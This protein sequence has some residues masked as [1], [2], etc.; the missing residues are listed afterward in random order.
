MHTP[1]LVIGIDT[2]GTYTDAVL[3]NLKT[4]DVLAWA[5]EP[6]ST[7]NPALAIKKTLAAIL[8]KSHINP[9]SIDLVIVSTTLATNALVENQGAEVG[10]LVIGHDQRLDVPVADFRYIPGGH[11]ARGIEAEPLGMDYLVQAIR[12]MQDHVDTYAICAMLAFDDPSHELVAAKAIE[13]LDP[14]PVFSSHQASTRPG[15]RE[16]ATT[17]VLNARLLPVMQ[18]FLTSISQTMME[19]GLSCPVGIARGDCRVMSL[20]Q[21]VRNSSSTVASGPAATAVFGA[22]IAQGQTA[23]VV[24]VGGTTSDITLICDGQPV[25]R[26][27]GMVV[28]SWSTHVRAVEMRTV[29]LGGDSLISVEHGNLSIGPARVLPMSQVH[30]QV[31]KNDD[32]QTLANPVLWLGP[33]LDSQCLALAPGQDPGTDPLL[34]QLAK[35]GPSTPQALRLTLGVAESTLNKSI[36]RLQGAHKIITCGFTPTDALHVLGKLTLGDVQLAHKSALI[37]GQLLGLEAV[38]FCQQILLQAQDILA[39]TL[40]TALGDQELGPVLTRALQQKKWTSLLDI[41]IRLKPQII[42]IGAAAPYLLPDVADKL[43][44][45]VL[46]PEYYQVGNALGAAYMDIKMINHNQDN[47]HAL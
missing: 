7:H 33:G 31:V 29:G 8:D 21:A 28:G 30:A 25:I 26:E 10:L 43:G 46:F 5:K 18:N 41:T 22:S 2:G 27:D 37:L 35:D 19:L 23:V 45:K 44:T 40:L 32:L 24:D 20:D 13:L 15:F 1:T 12:A 3:V 14:K 6:T 4:K 36:A 16:R 47:H 34:L 11:K 38:D 39:M 9:G 17:A 42:G